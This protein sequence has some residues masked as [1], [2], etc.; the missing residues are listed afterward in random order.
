MSAVTIVMAAARCSLAAVVLE[1]LVEHRDFDAT[2]SR[3]R[4]YH[5]VGGIT[6]QDGNDRRF[7][8]PCRQDADRCRQLLAHRPIAV[9]EQLEH[10]G[11][12]G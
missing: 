11:P 6:I 2:H 10:R 7:P 9:I 3:A 8:Q 12:I 1:Q 4:R 5:R